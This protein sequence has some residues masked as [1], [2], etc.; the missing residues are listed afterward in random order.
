MSAEEA[1]ALDAFCAENGLS[2]PSVIPQQNIAVYTSSRNHWTPN[3]KQNI[4]NLW[5]ACNF[6]QCAAQHALYAIS[7]ASDTKALVWSTRTRSILR[8]LTGEYDTSCEH[9]WLDHQPEWF[10]AS[11]FR[12]KP[13][14]YEA[15]MSRAAQPVILT[16]YGLASGGAQERCAALEELLDLNRTDPLNVVRNAFWVQRGRWVEVMPPQ[17][18]GSAVVLPPEHPVGLL[19][20]LDYHLRLID[21]ANADFDSRV[22][23]SIA[24]SHTAAAPEEREKDEKG[25]EVVRDGMVCTVLC[26]EK[27]LR[28]ERSILDRHEF[29]KFLHEQVDRETS[30]PWRSHS[31]LAL[32]P[33]FDAID[34][35]T[36]ENEN[37]LP[38]VTLRQLRNRH[39]AV[40]L[41]RPVVVPDRMFYV[42]SYLVADPSHSGPPD[43]IFKI[44]YANPSKELCVAAA[45]ILCNIYDNMFD[46]QVV[47]MGKRVR[48]PVTPEIMAHAQKSGA[49]CVYH[50]QQRELMEQLRISEN[51]AP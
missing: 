32:Q 3:Q 16:V 5:A 10:L 29:S 36:T 51:V 14:T 22:E 13:S 11:T 39:D 45:E 26:N 49:K 12:A 27:H 20:A 38:V 15:A 18:G 17:A 21:E 48:Q 4:A 8:E 33:D 2:A 35:D 30:V 40:R 23:R 43:G 34:D 37:G 19:F 9:S 6:D 25:G 1:A 42:L 41:H 7:A 46:F 31:C 44:S 24:A 50:M 28:V 47:E